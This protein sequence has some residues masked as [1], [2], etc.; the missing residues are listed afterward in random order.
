M[1]TPPTSRNARPRRRLRGPRSGCSGRPRAA[2]RCG[3]CPAR[4]WCARPLPGGP[5]IRPHSGSA[6]DGAR[7]P[8]R[9]GGAGAWPPTGWTRRCPGS[10][11]GRGRPWPT[12]PAAL[13]RARR[14]WADRRGRRLRR[15][16]GYPTCDDGDGGDGGCPPPSPRRPRCRRNRRPR[17]RPRR[18]RCRPRN[19]RY[20]T[21]RRCR[22]PRPRTPR[23]PRRS[24]P[25]D[26]DRGPDGRGG[27]AARRAGPTGRP[28][29]R[30]RRPRRRRR[31]RR[32]CHRSRRRRARGAP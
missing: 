12:S 1:P 19:P 4:S 21:A 18:S 17:S 7:R 31:H 15:N 26:H 9:R 11:P 23:R 28:H 29:R 8:G 16:P 30:C 6:V 22:H 14:C 32:R 10:R 13:A 2:V 20:R 25:R 3:S 27:G 24:A 5:G